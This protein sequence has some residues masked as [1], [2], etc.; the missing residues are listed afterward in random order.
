M[1]RALLCSNNSFA[2]LI[3]FGLRSIHWLIISNLFA[4]HDFGRAA[5]EILLFK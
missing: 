1:D 3:L 4:K 5:E 2:R